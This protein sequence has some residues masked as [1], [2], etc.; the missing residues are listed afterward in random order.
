MTVTEEMLESSCVV[1]VA[2]LSPNEIFLMRVEEKIHDELA[3]SFLRPSSISSDNDVIIISVQSS[4]S[5]SRR[6]K[7]SVDSGDSSAIGG[8]DLLIAVYDHLGKH[9]IESSHVV[10]RIHALQTNLSNHVGHEIHAYNSLCAQK[11]I[12]YSLCI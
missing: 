3:K 2:D 10:R 11:V 1:H 12:F 9:F 5:S 4:T 6:R 7:K 8:T